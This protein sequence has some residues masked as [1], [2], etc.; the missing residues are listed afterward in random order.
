MD[1]NKR[2]LIKRIMAVVLSAFLFVTYMPGLAYA[3]E[4]MPEGEGLLS[5]EVLESSSEPA[6]GSAAETPEGEEAA[7]VNEDD[8]SLEAPA[9]EEAAPQASDAAEEAASEEAADNAAAPQTDSLEIEGDGKVT[10][11]KVKLAGNDELLMGFIEEHAQEAMN[12]DEEEAPE[13]ADAPEDMLYNELRSLIHDVAVG[14]QNV[15]KIAIAPSEL[16]GN[17]FTYTADELG[18]DIFDGDEVSEDAAYASIAAYEAEFLYSGEKIVGKLLRNLPFDFYWYDKTIGFVERTEFSFTAE[19][20][21]GTDSIT[22]EPVITFAFSVAEE[23][24]SGEQKETIPDDNDQPFA[25]Y[26]T[27]S[28]RIEDANEA[29]E[30][31]ANIVMDAEDLSN[32]AK[33]RKYKNDICEWTS[34]ND[35]AA[36]AGGY[37]DPW[38]LIYV[39]DGDEDTEVVCEG[40]AKAFQ[41]LCDLT[42]SFEDDVECASVTGTMKDD[43]GAEAHMWNVVTFGGKNY[44]VDVTNCDEDSVGAPDQLFMAGWTKEIPN[45]Y[46]YTCSVEDGTV[47]IDYT[48]DED[49]FMEMSGSPFADL[50]DCRVIF[51]TDYYQDEIPFYTVDMNN[52]GNDT[53]S[54]DDLGISVVDEAGRT[55]APANYDL[56]FS[57]WA[58]DEN[59]E[60]EY[61]EDADLPL[62]VQSDDAKYG[63]TEYCVTVTSAEGSSCK[64][65]AEETF[66]VRDKHSLQ[67]LGSE[68]VF[69]NGMKDSW[70]MRDRYWIKTGNM[71]APSVYLVDGEDPL[72]AGTDYTLTYYRTNGD[73]S[74]DDPDKSWE[75]YIN[76]DNQYKLNAMPTEPGHYF[77]RITGKTPY[78]G[79]ATTLF[80]IVDY[81]PFSVDYDE[82]ESL[83]SDYTKTLTLNVPEDITGTL[84]ITG[85]ANT[86]YG[87]TSIP[88]VLDD[89]CYSFNEASGELTI[90][91]SEVF[92]AVGC[93]CWMDLNID[94]VDNNNTVIAR[95]LASFMFEEAWCEY[96]REN[97]RDILPGWDGHISER[98]GFSLRDHDNPEGMEGDYEVDSVEVVRGK[99]LLSEETEIVSGDDG[100]GDYLE[101]DDGGYHYKIKEWSEDFNYE[102]AVV[103]FLVTYRDFDDVEKSYTFKVNVLEEVY[104]VRLRSNDNRYTGLP[105]H[106]IGMTAGTWHKYYDEDGNY[107]ED[108]NLSC[109]WSYA[110]ASELDHGFDGSKDWQPAWTALPAG[111]LIAGDTGFAN[112][113]ADGNTADL[114]FVRLLD[115]RNADAFY[116]K[117]E[118]LDSNGE[119]RGSDW[120]G[121]FCRD[122]YNAIE[123]S[124]IDDLEVTESTGFRTFE[125]RHYSTD[126]E[127]N[128]DG[129]DY[130]VIDADFTLYFDDD[131]V[132]ITEKIE[133]DG[134][135]PTV[136]KVRAGRRTRGNKFNIERLDCY[137]TDIRIEASWT[138]QDDNG[139]IEEFREQTTYNFDFKN[140]DIWFEPGTDDIF[141]D[142]DLTYTLE[143]E[144][145]NDENWQSKFKVE[146]ELGIG[147]W[148]TDED[149]EEDVFVWDDKF[150][151]G[152]EYLLVTDGRSVKID[153]SSLEDRVN[154]EFIVR[155]KLVLKSSEEA[156]NDEEFRCQIR[157]PREDF[158]CDTERDIL[159]GWDGTISRDLRIYYENS[160]YP[161]GFEKNYIVTDVEAAEADVDKYLSDFHKDYKDN[162]E[163]SDDY[164]WYYRAKDH[165]DCQTGTMEFTVHY[166]DPEE[167]VAEGD[168]PTDHTYT[169][170]L[171][172][173]ED[174][175]DV[176]FRSEGSRYNGLPGDSFD[177]QADGRHEYYDENGDYRNDLDGYHFEWSLTR[178]EEYATL[179]ADE[180]DPSKATLRFKDAEEL[181]EVCDEDWEFGLD[182]MI[183]VRVDLVKDEEE[184]GNGL[185]GFFSSLFRGNRGNVV[186]SRED[187]FWLHVWYAELYPLELNDLGLGQSLQTSFELREYS[188]N[189]GEGFNDEK[190]RVAGID[191]LEFYFDENAF[192]ISYESPKPDGEGTDTI[193]V[194][195][196]DSVSPEN[197]VDNE[198]GAFTITRKA[199][200]DSE[201][202]VQ[203]GW[204]RDDGAFDRREQHYRFDRIDNDIRFN[205]HDID[206]FTDIYDFLTEN[207]DAEV[208]Y[209]HVLNI[210]D[211]LGADWAEYYA[212]DIS[213]SNGENSGD[214]SQAAELGDEDYTIVSDE[215]G[216]MTVTLTEAFVNSV[217]DSEE[218]HADIRIEANITSI[219]DASEHVAGAEAWFHVKKPETDY[220]DMKFNEDILPNE[221]DRINKV[222]GVHVRSTAYP[223]GR[224][225][226]YEVTG[227][228]VTGGREYL[229]DDVYKK[230]G[231]DYY[232]EQITKDDNTWWD[233]RIKDP[234]GVAEAGGENP[235]VSFEVSYTDYDGT[236]RTYPFTRFIVNERYFTWIDVAGGCD[237][238]EPGAEFDLI[239]VAWKSFVDEFGGMGGTGEGFTFGYEIIDGGDVAELE[240]EEGS[241]AAKLTFSDDPQSMNRRVCV[242]STAYYDGN[243]V[244]SIDRDFWIRDGHTE[245]FVSFEKDSWVTNKAPEIMPGDSATMKFQLRQYEYGASGA[246]VESDDLGTYRV[247]DDPAYSWSFDE[248]AVEIRPV[249]NSEAGEP[250]EKNEAVAKGVDTFSITRKSAGQ[251]KLILNTDY[252]DPK[253]PYNYCVRLE[254]YNSDISRSE[255]VF[256][257]GQGNTIEPVEEDIPT[258]PHG[259]RFYKLHVGTSA[260]PELSLDGK[261]LDSKYFSA[262]Y[263]EMELNDARTEW[264]RKDGAEWIT[265]FP[266][267]P[268]TYYCEIEGVAP[269]SGKRDWIDLIKVEDHTHT[270]HAAAEASCEAPGNSAYWSCDVCGKYFSDEAC[271][272][273]VEEDSWVIPA[274]HDYGSLIAE[275]AATCTEDGMA[276]HYECSKCNRLFVE[277]DGE[278]VEKTAD[279]LKIPATHN[280]GDL[281]DE[282]PA[283]CTEDGIAAHYECSVCHKLF[284]R[285][286]HEYIETTEENL[287]IKAGHNYGELITEV[288]ATCTEDG[289]A[290]HYECSKCHKLFVKEDDAYVEKT[291]EEL[292]LPAGHDYGELIA[293]VPATCTKAGM[294]AHYE[295]SK[296]HK[297]FVKEDDTYVEKTA[298]ELKITVDHTYGELIAEVPASCDN[299]GVAA[300]YECSECHR[301]FVKEGDAYVEKTADELKIP[302]SHDYGNQIAEVPATCTED[303]V[304]AHYEC[305]KCHKLFVKE[306]DAYVEKTAEQLKLPAGHDYGEQI[307]AVPA[308]CTE[309]GVAAHYECSKCHKL[310]VKEGNAYV[311]KTAEQ[312]K[313]PAGHDYGDQIAEVPATCTEDGMAAHYKCSKCNR[314]FVKEGDAYVEK[315]A[316]QLKLPAGHTLT[317]HAK[318]DAAYDQPGHEAYYECTVCNKLF[319]DA[320]GRNEISEPV[321]IKSLKD[322]AADAKADAD[323][324]KAIADEAAKTPG[325]AAIAAAQASEE[326]ARI[327]AEKAQAAADAAANDPRVSAEDKN[328]AAQAARDAAQAYEDAKAAT[329]KAKDDKAAADAA[330]QPAVTPPAA[331]VEIIDLPA[332]KISKPASAK[333]KLT[334]KWKKV[335]KKNLKKISGIQIQV[336]TDPGFTNIVKTATAGKKKTSKKIGGLQPKTKYYVRIRAYGA[337]NHY[338]VWKNKSGKTK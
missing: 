123:P 110:I 298:E 323:A 47:N 226:S 122:E 31:A 260:A 169:L 287:I 150:H 256:R 22:V 59:T 72:T 296:C 305:S 156:I 12:G 70:R 80:D 290:A 215:R 335:S 171:N 146:F 327:A 50:D 127:Q 261:A 211:K 295:C 288:P 173:T 8:L 178:G 151:K 155:G 94:F 157:E 279:Q 149:T 181:D 300:H 293:E 175:Y 75:E 16:R 114:E 159:A 77:V 271:T 235:A 126:A 283:T 306:G 144:V 336:A 63:I 105:G 201:I 99:D 208:E 289:M 78:L 161:E 248:N 35:E 304:A 45:G 34:Y 89:A 185:M 49:M 92:D 328:A 179:E 309:D 145:F 316:E 216:N 334:V 21:D 196:G 140:Y 275:V 37:G 165:E 202:N 20:S 310:F 85:V 162:D 81:T 303:G 187:D 273:E 259:D 115:D 194:R 180:D 262:R 118:V 168:T 274:S 317:T 214:G 282:V 299:D 189:G 241:P 297:L 231:E 79:A 160:E 225:F 101:Y 131:A 166:I 284:V 246:G 36:A 3:V 133:E 68:T 203:A 204:Q 164:W 152:Q 113:K 58:Y 320:E 212:C 73:P 188:I 95:G 249:I 48:F 254:N 148:E 19:S 128:L 313:L 141:I 294:A 321:I 191:R 25:V 116:V 64:G 276:A 266:T 170:T 67:W 221:S 227:V 9:A 51:G 120:N 111:G 285:A 325:D 167:E 97:D 331:P 267:V 54:I 229:A 172:I 200:W 218:G 311:E 109:Q 38:Q 100:T 32:Y 136:E 213:V 219:D 280:Y 83:W 322:Q 291:A 125:L 74:E 243:S 238:G 153:G 132:S 326:A 65:S 277:Q 224:D 106:D 53:L 278:Y 43:D 42:E 205:R 108:D 17:S 91:G 61:Y 15:P 223:D 4:G 174:V 183:N 210:G 62:G 330:S 192:D 272:T 234:A 138:E 5:G 195:D 301:L 329:Q 86:D 332:V 247:I 29:A 217:K 142:G 197:V 129:K 253:D 236:S 11:P 268:G 134:E 71:A 186:A 112:F 237:Q 264:D 163:S 338:S 10:V 96:D 41:F 55:V 182:E 143:G 121:F 135:E 333:K 18:V 307:A 319:S 176:G 228:K 324:K 308:T 30:N 124:A 193:A 26:E 232:L 265:E 44:L 244:A 318:Q 88:F 104:E 6:D 102:N 198:N 24:R 84:H 230:V 158:R 90:D 184:P 255:V 240:H 107:H 233:Y 2:S 315:T 222:N 13:D 137:D 206:V 257:D 1:T 40:Y 258:T 139:R 14:E 117:A 27:D 154:Q 28:E 281:I 239:A 69:E 245:M 57:Y 23:Y 252:G 82:M 242:R 7:G 66:Y 103:E 199:D 76:L 56:S 93:D 46:R 337:A 98:R 130:S 207:P 312:L 147:H 314:L 209:Q 87:A 52:S 177:L 286:E 190:Y 60:E 250:L 269:F 251:T 263:I 292:K 119:A 270:P 220:H 302:A 39:F 33:L